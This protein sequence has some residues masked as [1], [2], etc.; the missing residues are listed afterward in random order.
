MFK[1]FVED[2]IRFVDDQKINFQNCKIFKNGEWK[3]TK[4]Q[5]V[6]TGDILKIEN[7]EMFPCDLVLLDTSDTNGSCFVETSG[8]DGETDLKYRRVSD[9]TLNLFD[10]IEDMKDLRFEII[11][12]GPNTDVHKFNG[13]LIY[14][15]KTKDLSNENVVLRGSS[16]K[17]TDWIVGAV[18]YSGQKTKLFQN[19][20]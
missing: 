1:D 14:K 12:D 19:I 2:T 13:N 18:V 3:T 15:E 16:L 8:L 11:C 7:S 4:W 10:S 20:E 6:K 17:N 5:N 9:I